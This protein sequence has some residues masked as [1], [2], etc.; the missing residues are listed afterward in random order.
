MDETGIL[1]VV[2]CACTIGVLLCVV[3]G[4]CLIRKCGVI[5]R[6]DLRYMIG[7]SNDIERVNPISIN[8]DGVLPR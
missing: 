7:N 5:G 1:V 3:L 4:Y 8:I 6:G 2:I